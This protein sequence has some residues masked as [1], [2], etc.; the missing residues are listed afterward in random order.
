ME[1]Q[2]L[3]TQVRYRSKKG[4]ALWVSREYR[5]YREKSVVLET[6]GV[7]VLGVTQWKIGG[8][9][10]VFDFGV[11]HS[12]ILSGPMVWSPGQSACCSVLMGLG[13]KHI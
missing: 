13:L 4:L 1:L 5:L 11:S 3:E 8:L 9:I 12:A 10:I 7:R 6:K 2:G